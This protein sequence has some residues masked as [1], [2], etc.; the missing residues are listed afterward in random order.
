MARRR[1]QWAAAAAA[2]LALAAW[3]P[4]ATSACC[5]NADAS[6]P[7]EFQTCGGNRYAGLPFGTRS[8]VYA[9]NGAAATS[10]ALASQVGRPSEHAPSADCSA[11]TS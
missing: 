6:V 1:R 3:G 2:A 7:P 10:V 11:V 8:P 4:A 9:R 5:V